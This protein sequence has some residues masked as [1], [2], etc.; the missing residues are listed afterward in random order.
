MPLITRNRFLAEWLLLLSGLFVVGAVIGLTLY[1][2]HT[3]I[4]ALERDRLATQARVI[5]K[6]LGRALLVVDR[7]LTGIRDDLPGWQQERDGMARAS[8]RLRAFADA[9]R[10]VRTLLVFDA[11]GDVVA[12]NHPALLGK[13]FAHRP[14][15]QRAQADANP[16]VLY[17]SP[18]FETALG[19]WAMN[20]VRVVMTPDGKFAGIVSATLDPE[21]IRSQL[22]AVLYGTDMWAAIAHG[23]GLQVIMEPDRPGQSGKSLAQPGSFFSRHMASAHPAEVLEGVV[24]ATGELRMMALHTIR[25]DDVPM[26]KPL[27]VAVGRDMGVLYGAWRGQAWMGGGLF[28]LLAGLTVPGLA[29]AQHR[30]RRVETEREQAAAALARNEHFMRSLIDIIPGM[31]G[32][33][34]AELRCGFA[35]IA[36]REWFG[37]TPEQ[38]RGI[39][40]QELMNKALFEKNEPFIRAALAGEC[41]HFERTLTKADGSTG[42]TWAHYIPDVVDDQV[43]GFFVLVND[44]TELKQAQLQLEATNAALEKRSVESEAASRAKS[45]FVANMSHEIRTPM[46]AVLGLLELL[47]HTRLDG[48]QLDYVRKAEGAARSLLAILNDILDFSKVEAGRMQL[49]D[50]PFRLDE[51]LRNLSVMLSAALQDKPVEVL[52]DIAPEL[53]RALRGDPLRLQQVLLNLAGNAVKF[54]ERGEVIVSLRPVETRAGSARIEFA[55]RDTGIGIAAERLQAVFEGFTQAE[56][57]TTRHYGGTGLGLAISQRLVSLMG[58][59]LQVE[60]TPGAGSRFHF[61]LDLLRD[62]ATEQLVQRELDPGRL[63]KPPH[64]LIVDDNAM[65]RQVLA[66]ATQSF[67]W[68]AETAASGEEAVERADAAI[69]AGRPFDIICLDWLM[70]GLNGWDTAERIRAMEHGPREPVL[71]MVTAKGREML[72]E[73]I[74]GVDD[75]PLDGFLVK[76]VTP[77]MLFDAI[78]VATGGESV[79]TDHDGSAHLLG[80]PLA[81]LRLLLVED[82]PLNQQVARELLVHAGAW[83][84]VADDGRAALTLAQSDEALFDA[85]LMDIQMP[86]MDG[87]EATRRLR[88]SGFTVPII[89]MTANVLAA[90]RDACLAAGMNDHVGKPID[91]RELVATLLRQCG[92]A[93]VV[94]P[95]VRPAGPLPESPEGFD[96]GPALA[97]LNGDRSFFA[98]LA[99]DFVADQGNSADR[100]E[101]A[102]GGGDFT[103]ATRELHT[104]KGQAAMLGAQPL[105][106]LAAELESAARSG[107]DTARHVENLTRLRTLID[108]SAA[109]LL[110][111]AEALDPPQVVAEPAPAEPGCVAELLDELVPLLAENNLRALDVFEALKQ[112]TGGH[113]ERFAELD[114]AVQRLDFAAAQTL[115]AS[116]RQQGTT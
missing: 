72:E 76:P 9:M 10:S 80:R 100:I 46:N 34:D 62:E 115:V 7:T 20:V 83:V 107:E 74:A 40:I 99:R 88:A 67:G 24:A 104:L 41:Q 75:N 108:T 22:S 103:T 58:G 42:Y 105:A 63:P 65:A 54:T 56:G 96:L 43:R 21:E 89:A 114:R 92:R 95:V 28:V 59:E 113:G 70:P 78:A 25:P 17:V 13:N 77:S 29:I 84:T 52:F 102:W 55:V 6:N 112:A 38:M 36:Y 32:Y 33:W 66:N 116:L 53:P 3:A 111:L 18:P 14:Y 27:V 87:Y 57:S 8:H 79:T 85:V 94:A 1:R 16:D 4:G 26:D 50:T 39:H 98:Q 101:Q 19:V 12:A 44:I 31:V 15:F 86:G 61:T 82:N 30:R 51:L 73:R 97:R 45:A 93:E 49:D 110:T 5:D 60:S 23:D 35:N 2:D 106:N 48:H 90:D 69:A 81:G 11:E 68:S 64:V 37:K 71:L 91:S 109:S 47:Q